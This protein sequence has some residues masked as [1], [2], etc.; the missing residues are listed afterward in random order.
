MNEEEPVPIQ[1]VDPLAIV[2]YNP[3]N[4][5]PV[6]SAVSTESDTSDK[7]QQVEENPNDEDTSNV[8]GSKNIEEG[9]KDDE[10]S[11]DEEIQNVEENPTVKENPLSSETEFE[12]VDV[13]TFVAEILAKAK[14]ESSTGS[15][16]RQK[17]M[18]RKNVPSWYPPRP[19][20]K[21]VPPPIKRRSSK[22]RSKITYDPNYE[23]ETIDLS[24]D[25]KGNADPV[26]PSVTTKGKKGVSKTPKKSTPKVQEKPKPKKTT[27]KTAPKIKPK[28]SSRY[29]PPVPRK[30]NTFYDVCRHHID[31]K[32]VV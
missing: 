1:S 32:S 31:R 27:K 15:S 29:V 18:A 21:V 14:A 7:D 2:V 24:D 28:K 12:G 16:K 8:A 5:P 9:K 6:E 13:D 17:M 20:S 23:P 19:L 4:I 25:D 22:I 3:E 11:D 10:D 26:V 30:S